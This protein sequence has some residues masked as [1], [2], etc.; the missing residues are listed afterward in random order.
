MV[1]CRI[2]HGTGGPRDSYLTTVDRF[3]IVGCI[4]AGSSGT[5]FPTLFIRISPVRPQWCVTPAEVSSRA[6]AG[7]TFEARSAGRT[8]GPQMRLECFP[9][10]SVSV[11]RCTHRRPR[12]MT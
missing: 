6:R 10:S 7:G 1:V 11:R 9:R 4:R 5:C 2:N 8:V 12:G 3:R